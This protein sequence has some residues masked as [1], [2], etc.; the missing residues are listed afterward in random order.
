MKKMTRFTRDFVATAV[1]YK[2]ADESKLRDYDILKDRERGL[3][4]QQLANK[5]GVSRQ[6]I[7]VI[8]NK[9]CKP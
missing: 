4:Q 2:I 1:A 6:S 9:Y 5:Y 8:L 3:S 7:V